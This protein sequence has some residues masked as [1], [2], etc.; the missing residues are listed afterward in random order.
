[1][2]RGHSQGAVPCSAGLCRAMSPQPTSP[3][4]AHWSKNCITNWGAPAIATGNP[5]QDEISHSQGLSLAEM[6]IFHRGIFPSQAQKYKRLL[7]NP[8]ISPKIATW[9]HA[10][11]ED[12]LV[13]L[14]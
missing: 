13:R 14:G 9:L 7:F 8:T 11:G 12:V 6:L 3:L 4:L 1:M 10:H 2:E 5:T